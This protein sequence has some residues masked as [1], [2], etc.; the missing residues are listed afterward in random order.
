MA[1]YLPRAVACHL[2]AL[3]A[4]SF[5]GGHPHPHRLGPAVG[6]GLGPAV[7]YRLDVCVALRRRSVLGPERLVFHRV[8]TP[9]A[10]EAIDIVAGPA[11]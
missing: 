1:R 2:A 7:G 8:D 6:H 5:P 4:P 3:V 9:A 10:G 11:P